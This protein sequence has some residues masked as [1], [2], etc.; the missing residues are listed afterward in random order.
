MKILLS[1]IMHKEYLI[2]QVPEKENK[3]KY[4][5]IQNFILK[6]EGKNKNN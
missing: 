1:N 6:N 5:Q 3:D 2:G 4:E